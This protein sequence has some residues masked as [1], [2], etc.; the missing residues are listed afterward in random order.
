MYMLLKII[1]IVYKEGEL[2]SKGEIW[3]VKTGM[4]I[5]TVIWTEIWTTT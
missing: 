1:M 4:S 2:V 3:T 5:W